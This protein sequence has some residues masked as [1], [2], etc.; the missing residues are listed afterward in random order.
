MKKFSFDK[1]TTIALLFLFS[2]IIGYSQ[3]EDTDDLESWKSVNLKYKLDKKWEFDFEGQ[4]RLKNDISEISEYFGE[5][6]AEYSVTK[7]F[8][9]GAGFRYIWENDN[10]GAI[11]GYENHLRYHF[12]VSYK[13]KINDFSLKY[14]LRYQNKNELGVDDNANKHFR[15]KTSLGYNFKNWKLDPKLSAEIYHHSETGE[16]DGFDKYRLTLGTEYKFKKSGTIG[17]FYRIEKEL[18]ETIPETTNIIGLKYSY[19]FKNKKK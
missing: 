4:L 7:A 2:A 18:N 1:K 10:V 14:R 3:S 5:F 11:Q 16:E 15:L 9:L 12:D 8:K 13:H 17:L 19:T 6:N